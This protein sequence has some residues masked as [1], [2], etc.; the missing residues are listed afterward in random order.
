[1]F[2]QLARILRA[3]IQ[4]GV[5]LPG[6]L[7]P[8]ERELAAAHGI[9]K[10]TVRDALQLLR[11]WGLVVTVQGVGTRVLARHE[12]SEWS[13]PSGALVT[14]RAPTAAERR[15]WLIPEGVPV[16]VITEGDREPV[17]LPADRTALRGG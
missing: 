17:V 2:R 4:E 1:M 11:A 16:L 5:Y 7:L 8:T 15:R 13:I 9:G 10:D 12:V 6:E 3:E 14:S